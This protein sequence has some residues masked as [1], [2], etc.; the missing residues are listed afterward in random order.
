MAVNSYR[1]DE[2]MENSDKKKIIIRLFSYL[3]NYKKSV[4]GV[5]L[6]MA[7]TVAIQLVNPLLI[8]EAIDHHI[9]VG[10]YRGLMEIGIF[11]V[12][13]N[14]LF[15]IMVK[16]R[17]YVM[18]R[19]ACRTDMSNRSESRAALGYV[20]RVSSSWNHWMRM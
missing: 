8:E 18:S 4:I 11:A 5:L 3:K 7:V 14:I 16:V 10:D 13:L 6:C 19:C 9:A 2:H 15:L 1:E 12:A 17:M 20:F